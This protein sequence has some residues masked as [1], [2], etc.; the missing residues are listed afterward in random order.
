MRPP[1]EPVVRYV[2]PAFRSLVARELVEKYSFSQ[3][4]AARTLGTTQAAISHYLYSRRGNKRMKQLEAIPSVK[5]AANEI[6]REIAEKKL[7]ATDTMSKFCM[8]CAVLR[9][10]NLICDLHKDFTSLPEKCNMCPQ[11]PM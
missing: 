5:S 6:A 3:I 11:T 8:L 10:R 7:S 4:T 1:C 9:N 2:L